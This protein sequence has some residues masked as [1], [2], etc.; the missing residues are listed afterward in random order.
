MP[1]LT[2]KQLLARYRELARLQ[3]NCIK[4][5]RNQIKDWA[6]LCEKKGWKLSKVLE[7]IDHECGVAQMKALKLAHQ[8]QDLTEGNHPKSQVKFGP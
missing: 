8:V 5:V 6:A 4:D 3:G 1:D 7:E 2:D